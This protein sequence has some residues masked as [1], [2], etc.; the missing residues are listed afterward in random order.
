VNVLPVEPAVVVPAVLAGAIYLRGWVALAA[1]MPSR[2]GTGRAAAFLSGL[3]VLLLALSEPMD[4]LAHEF[5][6]IHMIQHLLLMLV[7]PPLLWIGAPVAPMLLG[8]PRPLRRTVA[9]GLGWR[10]VRRL[11]RVLTNPGVSWALFV[12][13]FWAWHVPGL[14]QLALR[15]DTWHDAEHLCFLGSALLFWR[16]VIL[17]WPARSSWPRWTMIPYVVLADV[18]SNVLAAIFTFAD[19]VVYP[20]YAAALQARNGSALED[21]AIAGVIMWLPGSIAFFV[22]V[23][24]LVLT[25]LEPAERG[26]S[27]GR[28]ADDATPAA[29]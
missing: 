18:Q 19:R 25:Q 24:W 20:A 29:R 27:V 7:A 2:F 12:I 21:Q 26:A 8:L 23:L 15:S 1:R 3:L 22:P 6:R 28:T 11:T 17:P 13:V 16:P 5:L 4:A 9:A 10:P 14:Y